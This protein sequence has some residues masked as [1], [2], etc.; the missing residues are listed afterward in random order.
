[1]FTVE[2]VSIGISAEAEDRVVLVILEI[3]FIHGLS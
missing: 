1:M 3:Y 2:Q